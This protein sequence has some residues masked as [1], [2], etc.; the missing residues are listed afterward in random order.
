MKVIVISGSGHI[1]T[2][3]VTK[4]IRAGHEVINITRGQSSP[5]KADPTW[6]DIKPIV[7]D[8]EKHSNGDFAKKIAELNADIVV[9]LINFTLKIQ[10]S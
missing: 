6:K 2:Y 4:L 3:L 5:Y 8:R 7:L 10:N 1:G 9:D